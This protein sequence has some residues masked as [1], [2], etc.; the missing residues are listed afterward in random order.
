MKTAAADS[1][2]SCRVDVESTLDSSSHRYSASDN[3]Q[4]TTPA[5]SS[6]SD[7][8]SDVAEPQHTEL[9]KEPCSSLSSPLNVDGDPSPLPADSEERLPTV[10]NCCDVESDTEVCPVDRLVEDD[11]LGTETTVIDDSISVH[12]ETQDACFTAI[13]DDDVCQSQPSSC[14]ELSTSLTDSL[15]ICEQGMIETD[16]SEVVV[17]SDYDADNVAVMMV[18]ASNCTSCQCSSNT[19]DGMVESPTKPEVED[20]ES[21]RCRSD[22]SESDLSLA[23]VKAAQFVSESSPPLNHLNNSAVVCERDLSTSAVREDSNQASDEAGDVIPIPPSDVHNLHIVALLSPVSGVSQSVEMET[24][25]EVGESSLP[26]M[27]GIS[28]VLEADCEHGG[29]ASK[30]DQP[31]TTDCSTSDELEVSDTGALHMSVGFQ[32]TVHSDKV[33]MFSCDSDMSRDTSIGVLMVCDD[34]GL[35]SSV[36]AEPSTVAVPDASE[37]GVVAS[38]DDGDYESLVT[39]T[40]PSFTG[41]LSSSAAAEE[42][43]LDVGMAVCSQAGENLT[44]CVEAVTTEDVMLCEVGA[45]SAE[46]EELLANVSQTTVDTSI[47][48]PESS[49]LSYQQ[50]LSITQ[51]Q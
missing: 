21:S 12:S 8:V 10:D 40:L 31:S 1:V 4:E 38:S 7:S 26:T 14:N 32:S 18:P 34:D 11:D 36:T 9:V 51:C 49:K 3:I 35:V 29:K 47:C 43:S 50:T 33:A 45:K 6:S 20:D 28:L 46:M 37:D 17:A 16:S 48:S 13:T 25:S 15:D 42:Q 27:D 30:L 39:E 22:V 23:E 24:E 2:A 19:D 44:E 5:V 41:T